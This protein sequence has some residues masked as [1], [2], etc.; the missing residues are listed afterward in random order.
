ML[1]IALPILIYLSSVCSKYFLL[2]LTNYRILKSINHQNIFILV[3]ILGTRLATNVKYRRE[4]I[5]CYITE[6]LSLISMIILSLSILKLNSNLESKLTADKTIYFLLS[7]VFFVSL[8]YLAVYD[9]LNYSIP[10]DTVKKI[11][12]LVILANL[13]I[14]SV[15]FLYYRST[16]KEIFVNLDFGTLSNVAGGFFLWAIYYAIVKI[17]KE[18][19]LGSG[20]IDLNLMIGFFL[21]L[22]ASI[23]FLLSTLFIGS[24]VGIIYAFVLK[25]YKGVVI[26]LVPIM[27]IAFAFSLGFGKNMYEI[28]F[29]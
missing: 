24:I 25:K 1:A 27:L 26:P 17:T 16:G 23:I 5:K 13:A 8:L 28:L 14:S 21:G 4:R 3:P 11:L 7:I 20:D 19:G 22:K 15:S 10:T 9:L 18:E 6:F 12:F 2:V 29:L